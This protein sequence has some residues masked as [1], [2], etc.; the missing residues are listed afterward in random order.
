MIEKFIFRLPLVLEKN[1]WQKKK[2]NDAYDEKLYEQIKW[3]KKQKYKS[4]GSD[5]D[6]F[7][8]GRCVNVIWIPITIFGAILLWVGF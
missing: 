6:A 1:F 7:C 4:Y 3:K 8:S 5:C 2:E